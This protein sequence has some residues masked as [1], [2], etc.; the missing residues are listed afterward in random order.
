MAET[1][2]LTVS[3][4]CGAATHT[5]TVPTSSLPIASHL[6]NCTT[7]RRISGTLLTSYI[8]ITHPTPSKPIPP[9]PDLSALTPYP[10]SGILT[11]YFC[12][13]CGT[14]MYLEYAVDGHFEAA[15]GTLRL[16]KE[17]GEGIEGVVE[18]QSCMWIED[19]RD[20][21]GSRFITH[22]GGKQL[23]RYLQE[24]NFT[25]RVPL[26]WRV[27]TPPSTAKDT[28]Q[29]GMRK[30]QATHATCH[31]AGVQFWITPPN[32]AS[33]TASSPYSDLLI[34]YHLGPNASENPRNHPWW[35]GGS[36]RDRFLAGTCACTTCRRALG[37][38]ITFWAF[39]PAVNIFLDADCTLPF[40][41]GEGQTREYWGSMSTFR[42]SSNVTRTFCRKCGANVFWDGDE[43]PSIIDVSVGLLNAD[44]GARAEH[45][46][47]WWPGRVSFAEDAQN[48]RLIKGLEDGLKKWAVENNGKECVAVWEHLAKQ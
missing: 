38:D 42:S 40:S 13:T 2:S 16:D 31:C 3:C 6:C 26:D 23:E 48:K 18:Y 10:S 43:R 37:F 19:T 32:E 11:R 35:L 47:T 45:I 28:F 1:K 29:K 20:G 27:D 44:D 33:K 5:F 41:H 17:E 30:T 8:N 46:L 15:T 22:V 36:N 25:S 14:H 34:P 24:P 9:K 39:V 21:G 12:R 7:S 4:L